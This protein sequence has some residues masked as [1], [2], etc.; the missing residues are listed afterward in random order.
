MIIENFSLNQAGVEQ[1]QAVTDLV[2]ILLNGSFFRNRNGFNNLPS[3]CELRK[4]LKLRGDFILEYKT[5]EI[6]PFCQTGKNFTP[7]I[8]FFE[9]SGDQHIPIVMLRDPN[10]DL[11]LAVLEENTIFGTDPY[12]YVKIKN[13]YMNEP[14]IEVNLDRTPNSTGWSLAT[15]ACLYIKIH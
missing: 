6:E 5:V 11:H 7:R 9:S 3:I 8:S 1:K 14:T 12:Q 13:S 2:N 15:N 10:G 4:I